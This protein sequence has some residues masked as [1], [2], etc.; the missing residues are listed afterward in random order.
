LLA[1]VEARRETVQICRTGSPVAELVPWRHRA[2]PLRQPPRLKRIVFHE[3]PSLPL[4]DDDWPE[5]LRYTREG[6]EHT[7][8]EVRGTSPA[9]VQQTYTR[10]G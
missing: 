4:N 7:E 10:E 3:D 2:N 8:V 5:A 9:G 6:W 1:L